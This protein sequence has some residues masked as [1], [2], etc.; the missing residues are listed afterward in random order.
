MAVAGFQQPVRACDTD[1]VVV[2]L[3]TD[4]VLEEVD[5]VNFTFTAS[6]LG[7]RPLKELDLSEPF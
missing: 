6:L 2:G 4:T 5:F 3:R 7:G 1:E